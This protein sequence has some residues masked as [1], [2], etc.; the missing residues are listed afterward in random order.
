MVAYRIR[1]DRTHRQCSHLFP[2]SSEILIRPLPGKFATPA[3]E[4]DGVLG[5]LAVSSPFKLLGA[6]TLTSP[7]GC[8]F[9]LAAISFILAES[10]PIFNYLIA[11]T[12]PICFAPLTLILPALFWLHGCGEW[13]KA[14]FGKQDAY[15]MHCLTL[16]LGVFLTIAGTYVT[17]QSIINAYAAGTIGSAFS[18]P[19]KSNSSWM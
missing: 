9:D 1:N 14:S 10:I 12:G 18:F 19:D 7:G 4:Y 5:D 6:S 11:L 8:T 13:R 3:I 2:S 16:L 17:V 15:Y